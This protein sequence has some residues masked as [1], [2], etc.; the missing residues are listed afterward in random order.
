MGLNRNQDKKIFSPLV[1]WSIKLRVAMSDLRHSSSL[2]MDLS[3]WSSPLKVAHPLG[4]IY[5]YYRRT[6]EW[7]ANERN[8]K[9]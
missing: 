1:T 7:V 4:Y 9:K 3:H 8:R 2:I 6:Y 5:P